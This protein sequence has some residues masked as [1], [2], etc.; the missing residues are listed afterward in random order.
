MEFRIC[1]ALRL[2]RQ[3]SVVK[4]WLTFDQSDWF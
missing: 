1:P 3:S 2:T 4:E